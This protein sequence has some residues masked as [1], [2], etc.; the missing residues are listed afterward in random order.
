MKGNASLHQELAIITTDVL[1]TRNTVVY[2]GVSGLRIST[3]TE[4]VVRPIT[5]LN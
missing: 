2:S 5:W 1:H 4:K 3:F